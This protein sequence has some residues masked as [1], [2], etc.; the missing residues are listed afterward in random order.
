MAININKVYRTV[1]SILNKEGRGFLTPDQFN[2]IGRQVQ[3]DLLERAFYD[4]NRV[5]NNKVSTIKSDYSNLPKNIKEK[6]DV[7]SK[8]AALVITTGVAPAPS[9]LY[10][11]INVHT[12]NRTINVQ[13]VTKSEL[14]QINASDLT[15]PSASFPVYYKEG[16]NIKLFP[17]TLSAASID[18]IKIPQDPIWAYTA[19]ASGSYQWDSNSSQNFELHESDEIDLT[20]KILGYAGIVIKD[21]TVVQ[22][23]SSEESKIIQLENS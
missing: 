4:Y 23:A 12:S 6:I 7:F 22:A 16:S 10:R 17:I 8:E 19:G 20:I 2:K 9:D 5:I 14:A 3:L 15:A 11:I 13:E 18:Y 21:P 1:L